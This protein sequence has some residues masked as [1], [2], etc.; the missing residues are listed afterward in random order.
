MTGFQKSQVVALRARQRAED[1][2]AQPPVSLNPPFPYAVESFDPAYFRIP[3][4]LTP[5]PKTDRP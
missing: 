5:V 2:R 1:R 3:A 4:E